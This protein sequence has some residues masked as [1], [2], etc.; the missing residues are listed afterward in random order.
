L[1]RAR[2]LRQPQTPAESTL[3]RS[4]RNRNLVYKFRR[5]H[6]IDKFIIDFYCAQA[7]L[8]IEVDG[9]SH[10][11][12]SQQEYDTARTAYLEDLGNRVIRFT[13][14]DIRYNLQAVVDEILRV[15]ESSSGNEI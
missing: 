7:K 13:N 1:E 12:A 15:I 6:P 5:Q 10:L 8:C 14:N 4:L 9:D 2:V 11:E 3:W